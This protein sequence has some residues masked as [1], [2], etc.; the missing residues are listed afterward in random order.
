M[1]SNALARGPVPV[2]LGLDRSEFCFEDVSSQ[3]LKRKPYPAD[4]LGT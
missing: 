1:L 3:S 2:L 4:R